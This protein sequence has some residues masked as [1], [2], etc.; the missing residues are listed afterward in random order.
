MWG[1]F[2]DKIGM[3]C[4]RLGVLLCVSAFNYAFRGLSAACFRDCGWVCG[5]GC[6]VIFDDKILIFYDFVET[7]EIVENQYGVVLVMK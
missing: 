4:D 1:G 3:V 5:R 7:S 2:G 6:E